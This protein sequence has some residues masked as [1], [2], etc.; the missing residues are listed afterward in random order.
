MLADKKIREQ[1]REISDHRYHVLHFFLFLNNV[2]NSM[3]QEIYLA[4]MITTNSLYIIYTI[5]ASG[6]E[7]TPV[8]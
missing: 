6:R 7:I 8:A 3:N 4:I 2:K 1:M 5:V